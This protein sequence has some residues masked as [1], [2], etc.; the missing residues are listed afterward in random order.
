MEVVQC[1]GSLIDDIPAMLIAKHVFPDEGVEVDI[2]ELKQDVDVSLIIGFD[3]L[4]QLYNILMLE[5]FQKHY[6]PICA[7]GIC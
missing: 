3:D 7:L 6:L 4:L 5:L 1:L 2:H